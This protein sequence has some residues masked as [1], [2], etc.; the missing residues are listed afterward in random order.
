M[1]RTMRWVGL[2]ALAGI[3]ML[4][5]L[6]VVGY[7]EAIGD[8][9][10]RRGAI[11]LPDWPAGAAPVSVALLSDIHIGNVAMD[12][13]RLTRIVA[14]VKARRP[15]LV[16]L[17]GDFVVGHAAGSSGRLARRLIGPL[18]R[19]RAPLG[20]FAVLG[21]HDHW[22]G[23][24]AV[25]RALA[26]AGIATLSNRA[27]RRGPVTIVGIDDAFSD[28]ADPRLALLSADG[29][30]GARIVVTHSPD[31]IPLLPQGAARLVLAGHTHCGQIVWPNGRALATRSPFNGRRLFDPRYRCGIVRDSR[32]TV[33]VTA[34]LGSGTAPVRLGAPP[35]WWLVTLGPVSRSRP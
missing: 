5:V 2:V 12:E 16:L 19:L 35:D 15:D 11:D 22:T 6:L 17:A 29:L 20:V 7:R 13:A 8:P 28:H 27:V 3:A 14:Q 31:A 23:A 21:N 26:E 32:R 33:I 4:G 25:T 10:V 18:S 1:T 24:G 9:V 34:G 30:G